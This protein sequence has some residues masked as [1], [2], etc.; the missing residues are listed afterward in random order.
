MTSD[1]SNTPI[2]FGAAYSVYVRIARLALEEKGVPY[3]LEEVDI[4]AEGGPP[5]G[6]LE[7]HPFGKIPA[8]EHDGFRLFEAAA[9]CRYVDDAFEGPALTPSDVRYRALMAQTIGMLDSYGYRALV[10]DVYVEMI[11]KPREGGRTDRA[12]VERGMGIA[13]KVAEILD[14]QVQTGGFLV[15]DALSLADLHAWPMIDC[16][17]LT[18]PG[19]ELIGRHPALAAWGTAMAARPSAI[20]T[21]S[22]G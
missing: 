9:I 4:F 16:F 1:V 8:F 15:G 3:R 14:R 18:R 20:A 6:Y 5:A 21:V 12:V 2:L 7:R 17:L 22:P 19:A 10:W 11:A 13:G